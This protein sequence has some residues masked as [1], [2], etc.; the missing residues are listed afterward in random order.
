MRL[1]GVRPELVS[2][3]TIA[4]SR[5]WPSG[6]PTREKAKRLWPD[7]DSKSAPG[8]G[9]LGFSVFRPEPLSVP[10]AALGPNGLN[11]QDSAISRPRGSGRPKHMPNSCGILGRNV[12]GGRTENRGFV[13]IARAWKG[14]T[15]AK[16]PLNRRFRQVGVR[17]EEKVF[18]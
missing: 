3:P 1:D 17:L 15:R 11:D 4:I 2:V 14:P 6:R 10:K 8:T 18:P 9:K 13:V 5:P 12:S 7:G 16:K